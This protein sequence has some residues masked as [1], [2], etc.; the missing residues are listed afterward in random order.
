M[1]LWIGKYGFK[2]LEL[3]LLGQSTMGKLK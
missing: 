3:Y 1:I 2:G